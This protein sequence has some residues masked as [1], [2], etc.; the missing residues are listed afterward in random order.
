MIISTAIRK[1]AAADLY[2]YELLWIINIYNVIEF[3]DFSF[4]FRYSC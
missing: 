3:N 4:S 1:I 2:Y